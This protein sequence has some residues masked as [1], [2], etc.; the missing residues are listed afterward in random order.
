MPP[1]QVVNRPGKKVVKNILQRVCSS[2]VP[3]CSVCCEEYTLIQ[4]ISPVCGHDDLCPR[5]IKRHIE[6]EMNNK[7]DVKV[8]CP[9]PHCT[10]ELTYN[11]LKRLTSKELFDRYDNLLL[12]AEIRG[13]SNLRWCKA[14]DCDFAQ[15]HTT[16]DIMPIITC[17]ACGQKSCFTHDVPW[18]DGL[19]CE[20]F[21][22]QL[23]LKNQEEND[24]NRAYFELHT[25][26]CPRCKK[27]IEKNNG[28][29]HMTCRC[30]YE[31]CWSC[32]SDYEKI[33]NRGNHYHAPTCKHYAAYDSDD[34]YDEEVTQSRIGSPEF[35]KPKFTRRNYWQGCELTIQR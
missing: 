16:G 4:Q 21:T 15:E 19:T 14:P 26:S 11:D 13:I 12:R 31:F 22:E 24:A 8:R 9:K 3:E 34:E 17:K 20:E 5:C 2:C 29:D 1:E 27:P 35:F 10:Y 23:R 33:R 32:L 25:K 7:E 28:C 6:T 30:G 18:H